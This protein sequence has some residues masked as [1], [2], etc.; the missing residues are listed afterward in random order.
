MFFVTFTAPLQATTRSL[1]SDPDKT[2]PEDPYRREQFEI[3]GAGFLKVSTLNGDISVQEM[4]YLD[5]VIVELYVDRGFAIWSGS[6]NLDNYRIIMMQR[7]NEIIASVE[8]KS[9]DS[10][11][12]SDKMKFTFKVYVPEKMS[13]KLKT[14]GGNILISGITGKHELKT[15]G[16]AIVAS[17]I[18]GKINAFT[19]GG[20][21]DITYARGTIFAQTEGGNITIEKSEGEL[22]LKVNG[23][24]IVATRIS[25]SMLAQVAGGDIKAGFVNITQ[26]MRLST[27]YG[28]IEVSLPENLGYDLDLT[29][30][31]IF[32]PSSE[33]FTGS[34]TPNRVIGKLSGGGTPI[35]LKSDAGEITLMVDDK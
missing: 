11:L 34:N 15:S 4:P 18:D 17:D 33:S 31:N 23:G 20:N 19:A 6:K 24:Q 2:S 30:L 8:P 27:S 35:N 32:I 26:G 9:G 1:S 16:G 10:N 3:E 28:N 14:S 29:G 12:F 21:I 13:T 25:G 22:R 5:K 7:G